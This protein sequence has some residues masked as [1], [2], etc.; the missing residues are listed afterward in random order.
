MLRFSISNFIKYLTGIL[1][2]QG[3][4]AMLVYTGLRIPENDIRLLLVGLALII[5]VLSSLWF[6]SIAGQLGKDQLAKAKENFSRE[7]EKIR[8][9]AEREKAKVVK[10]THR[11]MSKER[12]KVQNKAN[13]TVG[14]ALTGAVGLGLVM[15]MTQFVTFGLLTLSTAGG[16]LGGY[17]VRGRRNQKAL[18]NQEVGPVTTLMQR[19]R[20]KLDHTGR[21]AARMIKHNPKNPPP[22]GSD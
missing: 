8:L 19:T 22:N 13:L 12:G 9:R 15:L 20:T 17:L 11:E 1:L 5:G 7:R 6:A 16:A 2:I 14:M 21:A 4:T 18:A 3:A 10:Q